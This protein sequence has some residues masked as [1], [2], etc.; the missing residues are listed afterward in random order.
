DLSGYYFSVRQKIHTN[1]NN[2][3]KDADETEALGQTVLK[4][5]N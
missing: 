2:K 3:I 1:G 4:L 5:S